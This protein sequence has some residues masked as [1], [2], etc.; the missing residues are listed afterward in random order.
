[1]D[2]N[3]QSDEAWQRLEKS[4]AESLGAL[5]E[6]EYLIISSKGT[7]Y[8]VQFMNQGLFGIRA[9]AKSNSYVEPEL[10]LTSAQIDALLHIGWNPPTELPT[11]TGEPAYPEGSPN[12][13]LDLPTSTDT[14][15]LAKLA[16]RTLI[17]VYG[18]RHPT[19]LQYKASGPDDISIRFPNLGLEHDLS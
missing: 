17:D 12:Y 19:E 13:Y 7:D 2:T 11:P 6:D 5:H 3:P 14:T 8:F 16:V 9:E 4:I 10:A 18:I 15:Q 1:M